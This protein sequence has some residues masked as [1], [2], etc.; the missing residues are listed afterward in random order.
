MMRFAPV[1]ALLVCAACGG[2][3]DRARSSSLRA[4]DLTTP[5]GDNLNGDNLNGD[6]LNGD[7]L[8]GSSIGS[9]I[10]QVAY[11]G[12]WIA[13]SQLFVPRQGHAV[14]SPDDSG[15]SGVDDLR[16]VRSGTDVAGYG[17]RAWSDTGAMLTLQIT[18]VAQEASPDD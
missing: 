18:G 6:N 8:N 4:Q 1:L 16:T 17:F 9:H 15:F 14:D 7:N 13:G 12:A 11:D 5:N 2:E 3:T 10:V